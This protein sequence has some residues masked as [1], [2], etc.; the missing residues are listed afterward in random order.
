MPRERRIV[1]ASRNP[2]KVRELQAVLAEMDIQ[3]VGLNEV[4]PQGKIPQPPEAGATFAENARSKAA[5]YARATGCWALADDSGLVVDALGGA[6]G[7]GSA[8]YAADRCPPGAGRAEIDAANNARL[9]EELAGVEDGLR[10]AR[11]VCHL[12][13]SDGRGTLVEACG[14]VEGII[15]RQPR[16]TNGFGYDPLFVLPQSG[17]TTA[18]LSPQQKNRISHRGRA[19]RQFAARLMQLL[20]GREQESCPT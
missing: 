12:A 19:G 6:P 1:L 18:Q 7:T 11:F 3:A 2:G 20:K 14:T 5:C 10:T 13:L 9:L 15:G 8:R 17:L 16:G 4:D